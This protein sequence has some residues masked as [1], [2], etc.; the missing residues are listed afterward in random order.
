MFSPS[1]ESFS[2][3]SFLLASCWFWYSF[4]R[5]KL[6]HCCWK[7]SKWSSRDECLNEEWSHELDEQNALRYSSPSQGDRLSWLLE[8][9]DAFKRLKPKS[10]RTTFQ[11]FRQRTYGIFSE[12]LYN[13]KSESWDL[14]VVCYE[15]GSA[16][17]LKNNQITSSVH[18]LIKSIS[19]IFS[20]G[21]RIA[22][23]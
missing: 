8:K 9:A 18:L 6:I 22:I 3:M 21:W 2:S 15:S 11:T 19:A 16:T 10:L 1:S 23:F 12:K 17:G 4:W 13:I 7:S 14:V 5:R 20:Y